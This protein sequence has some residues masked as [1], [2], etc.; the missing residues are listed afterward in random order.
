LLGKKQENIKKGGILK[1]INQMDS[2]FREI[3]IKYDVD[4]NEYPNMEIL[5]MFYEDERFVN[6]EFLRSIGILIEPLDLRIYKKYKN[7]KENYG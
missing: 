6:E 5:R 3:S 2:V 1:M 4:L 7:K